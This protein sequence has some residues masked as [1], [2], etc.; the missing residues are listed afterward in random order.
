MIQRR[1]F[2]GSVA[3][4]CRVV[5]IGISRLCPARFGFIAMAKSRDRDVAA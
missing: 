5:R 2:L 3:A 4:V 1:Q